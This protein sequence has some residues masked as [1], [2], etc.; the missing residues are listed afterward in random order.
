V[1]RQNA[2]G[3]TTPKTQSVKLS[4]LVSG[5]YAQWWYDTDTREIERI[6]GRLNA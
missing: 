6:Y 1:Y 3:Q 2:T 5:D 4:L